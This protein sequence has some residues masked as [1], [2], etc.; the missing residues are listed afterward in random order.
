MHEEI[1]VAVLAAGKHLLVEKPIAAD[2]AAAD[3]LVDRAR[4][5]PNLVSMVG[6]NLRHHPLVRQARRLIAS[7]ALGDVEFVRTVFSSRVRYAKGLPGWRLRRRTGGG[8]LAD[9][10]VHHFDLW[11]HLLDVE[12]EEVYAS[13]LSGESD[14]WTAAVTARLTGGAVASSVFSQRAAEGNDVEIVGSGGRLTISFYRFDG[15]E[16]RPAS[17]FPGSL[18]ARALAALDTARAVPGALAAAA[19]GGAFLESYRSQWTHFAE[20]VRTG[21][22]VACTFEEGRR[23]LEISLAAIASADSNHPVRV[24]TLAG[25]AR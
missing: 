17:V 2:L 11:R 23:A 16:Y 3:A 1:G 14:D 25:S 5:S 24:E 8:V 22:P 9:I 7:G 12:V 4:R 10:A 13:S 15:L 6:F 18:K 20:C 19:H 21:A